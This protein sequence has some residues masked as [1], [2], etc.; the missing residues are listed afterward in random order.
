MKR[1]NQATMCQGNEYQSEY[2][3]SARNTYNAIGSLDTL[4]IIGV[5]YYYNL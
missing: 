5:I 2:V 1:I 4:K 3:D